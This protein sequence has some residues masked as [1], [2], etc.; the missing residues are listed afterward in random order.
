MSNKTKKIL[1]YASVIWP[2][3]DAVIGLFK[4]IIT[5]LKTPS[6]IDDVRKID[7]QIKQI[8]EFYNDQFKD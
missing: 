4:G 7:Q 1:Y 3:A 8:K 6:I 5:V 2:L